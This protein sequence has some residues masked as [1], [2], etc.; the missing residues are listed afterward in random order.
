[1]RDFNDVFD[2][3]SLITELNEAREREE[4]DVVSILIGSSWGQYQ[5][6]RALEIFEGRTITDDDWRKNQTA[7]IE[8]WLYDVQPLLEEQL[9]KALK[10]ELKENEYLYVGVTMNNDLVIF[11]ERGETI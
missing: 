8:H 3:Y 4:G 10:E 11:L 6:P 9:N 2:K 5:T 7:F 1:M